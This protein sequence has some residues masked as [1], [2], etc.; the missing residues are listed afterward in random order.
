MKESYAA[1][2]RVAL[3]LGYPEHWSD[4]VYCWDR[5]FIERWDPTSFAWVI[6]KYGSHIMHIGAELE[7][8]IMLDYAEALTKTFQEGDKHYYIWKAG[9]LIHCTSADTWLEYI[10]KAERVRAHPTTR[11]QYE[12][13]GSA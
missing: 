5:Q 7:D 10:R 11:R 1:I 3:K 6:R 8:P 13:S 2:E 12:R 9:K 4:D